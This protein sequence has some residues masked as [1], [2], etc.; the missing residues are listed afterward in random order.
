F[1]VDDARLGGS[2]GVRAVKT[3]NAGQGFL[4]YPNQALA[5]YLGT[6]QSTPISARNEYTDVLPSF[7][8]KWEFAPNLL[9]RFAFSKAIARPDF[10]QMQAY[11]ILNAGVVSGYTPP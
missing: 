10:S 4:V 6:G 11:Q 2:I 1:G 3:R 8:V 9:A 5:P 7:N